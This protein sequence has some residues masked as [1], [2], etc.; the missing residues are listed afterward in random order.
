MKKMKYFVMK[1]IEPYLYILP[2]L[3]VIVVF[4]FLP[5]VDSVRYSF[6]NWNPLK[7]VKFTGLENYIK[8]FHSKDFLSSLKLTFI[9]VAMSVVIL[10]ITG[11]VYSVAVEY[12]V[13]SKRFSAVMRTILFIPMMMSYV[14][15]GLLWQMIYDPNLGLVNSFLQLFGL[16][17][18][19]NPPL[20]LSNAKLALYYAFIPAIWQWSGFGMVMTTA[21]MMG[22][23]SDLTEAAAIDGANRWQAF[24]HVVLPQL[25]PTVLSGAAINLIGGFKAFDIIYVMTSGGPAN[26][27]RVTSILM[28]RTAFTENKYGYACSMAVIIFVI[29]VVLTVFFNK[30]RRY[31]DESVGQGN[32]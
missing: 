18:P 1:T 31:V 26:A 12:V 15:I 21:A 6:T 11:L 30:F 24:F 28:Y 29:S 10:P 16:I 8:L 13:H 4:L 25:M 9:W 17:D 7:E 23:S 19:V 3:L 14:A 22:I 27:T 20:Y 5:M 2:G 32:E